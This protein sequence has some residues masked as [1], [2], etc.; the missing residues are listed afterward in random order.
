MNSPDSSRQFTLHP[1]CVQRLDK[2]TMSFG[3]SDFRITNPPKLVLVLS[4]PFTCV[5]VKAKGVGLPTGISASFPIGTHASFEP[6]RSAGSIKYPITGTP[7]AA[8]MI[9][10]TTPVVIFMKSRRLM[11]FEPDMLASSG[12]FSLHR[13]QGGV[14]GLIHP[15]H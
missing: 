7:I 8:V 5:R 12:N 2:I 13:T 10:P 14:R 11:W 15:N 9:P 3:S 1:R 4:H 6:V